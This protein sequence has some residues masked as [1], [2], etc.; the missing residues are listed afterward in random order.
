[1][2]PDGLSFIYDAVKDGEWD[3]ELFIFSWK[4]EELI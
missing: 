3:T 4:T 2:S 1:M